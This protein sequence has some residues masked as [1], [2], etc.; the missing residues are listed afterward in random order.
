VWAVTQ[1]ELVRFKPRVMKAGEHQEDKEGECFVWFG[2]DGG[3]TPFH[4]TV[5]VGTCEERKRFG[6]GSH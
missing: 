6:F 4:I 2:H 5:K 1:S 3:L